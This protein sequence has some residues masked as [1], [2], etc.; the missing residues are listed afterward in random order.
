M[1]PAP[2]AYEAPRSLERALELLAGDVGPGIATDAVTALAGGQSLVP[3]L[4]FRL[5]RPSLLVDLNGI[6]EL[7]RLSVGADGKL[8]IGALTRQLALE[9]SP[10]VAAGWPLLD[11]AVRMVAHPAIRSRGTVG[12]SAAHADPRAELPAALLALRARFHLR[13][14]Q[15]SRVLDAD[16]FFVGPMRT[17]LRPGELL[18]EIEVPAS[19]AGAG[20]VF[21]EHARTH[22]DF[23]IAAVAL[24]VAPGESAAIAL[25]GAGPAAVRAP[26]AEQ[27]LLA[28]AGAAEVGALA[29]ALAGSSAGTVAGSSAGASAGDEYRGALIAALVTR[30][31]EQVAPA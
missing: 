8:R 15:E 24:I 2:F 10:A 21:R 19:P 30:A 17:A 11:Q 29:G 16:E 27:A 5:A 28:G 9:R 26:A 23:A 3:M 25:V 31:I 1:K 22:G 6:A 18:T 4:N 7:E 12:G 20:S 14:L 13:S